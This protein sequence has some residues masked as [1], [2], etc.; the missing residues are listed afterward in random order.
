VPFASG[1]L[2]DPSGAHPPAPA[3]KYAGKAAEA[4]WH[5]DEEQTRAWEPLFRRDQG[6]KEQLLALTQNGAIAPL[7]KGWGLQ[8]LEFRKRQPGCM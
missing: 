6:K 3:A 5:F 8:E 2:S 1:W 4:F 7:W